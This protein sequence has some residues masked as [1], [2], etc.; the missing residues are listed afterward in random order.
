MPLPSNSMS[1][2]LRAAWILVKVLGLTF[3][4]AAAITFKLAWMLAGRR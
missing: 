2:A 1:V 3:R 4:A